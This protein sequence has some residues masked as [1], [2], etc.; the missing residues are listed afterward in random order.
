VDIVATA[1]ADLRGIAG[2]GARWPAAACRWPHS[3]NN[4]VATRFRWPVCRPA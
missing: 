2:W 4:S 1:L 3:G